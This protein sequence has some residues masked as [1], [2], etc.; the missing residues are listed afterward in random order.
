MEI[1][2]GRLRMAFL[3]FFISHIPITVMIDGQGLLSKLYPQILVNVVRWY[4]RHF[5]DVLM[6]QAPSAE[7]VWFSSV[8]CCELLFQLP[9]FFVATWILWTYPSRPEMIS[10]SNTV[11]SHQASR[12]VST[13]EKGNYPSWFRTACLVYGSHVCTTLVPIMATFAMNEDM[14]IGQKAMTM[15]SM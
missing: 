2:C 8:I 3:I 13:P 14:S 10:L 7:T 11:P 15:S 5:G 6:G 12:I 4:S 9:F 1:I